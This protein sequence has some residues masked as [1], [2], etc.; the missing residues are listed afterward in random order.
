MSPTNPIS[1]HRKLFLTGASGVVGRALL[2]QLPG[3][4]PAFI[5]ADYRYHS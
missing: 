5:A 3:V 4:P 2:K 1:T